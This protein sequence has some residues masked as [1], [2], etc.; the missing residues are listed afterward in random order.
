MSDICAAGSC[1][2]CGCSFRVPSDITRHHCAAMQEAQIGPLLAERLRY[3]A[4]HPR[5]GSLVR[6]ERAIVRALNEAGFGL[7]Y[8]VTREH[9]FEIV[10]DDLRI[11][12]DV[13]S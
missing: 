3:E 4:E 2:W 9:S 6:A 13:E 11:R 8:Q 7:Q 10:V 1:H 12:V 5:W